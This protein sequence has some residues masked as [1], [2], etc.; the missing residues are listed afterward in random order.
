MGTSMG[1]V[2]GGVFLVSAQ[3]QGN[4]TK[5]FASNNQPLWLQQVTGIEY[6]KN[7][8]GCFG[9]WMAFKQ[10]DVTPS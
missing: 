6:Q 10:P 3:S 2:S 1:S 4:P 7:W 9:N 5:G 8:Y